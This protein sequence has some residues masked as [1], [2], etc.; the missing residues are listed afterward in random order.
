MSRFAKTLTLN[1]EPG[2]ASERLA[3]ILKD[4]RHGDSMARFREWVTAGYLLSECGN[5]IVEYMIAR[6]RDPRTRDL[7]IED[8]IKDL[9]SY[10]QRCNFEGM[11]PPALPETKAPP[12]E[13][14]DQM[15]LKNEQG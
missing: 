11:E 10:I 1:L 12:E 4:K 13:E 15:E 8:R 9:L 3:A 5:G 14:D 2:E 7:S 6:D